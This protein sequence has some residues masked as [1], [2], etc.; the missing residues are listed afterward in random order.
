MIIIYFFK[1]FNRCTL[2]LARA[3]VLFEEGNAVSRSSNTLF[4]FFLELGKLFEGIASKM[5]SRS[6]Q[7][8]A[9]LSNSMP[10]RCL[11][12][13][14]S[15][16]HLQTPLIPPPLHLTP[17]PASNTLFIIRFPSPSTPFA[18]L[19]HSPAHCRYFHTSQSRMAEAPAVLSEE[20]ILK[21][22]KEAGGT[23]MCEY[24][25]NLHIYIYIYIYVWMRYKNH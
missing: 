15:L 3:R 12:T 23:R 24:V 2:R 19:R 7:F 16:Q 22:I 10:L 20:E 1:F 5:I 8:C 21:R 17:T 13:S 4:Y 6:I 14:P 9:S 25:F 11:H 18:K